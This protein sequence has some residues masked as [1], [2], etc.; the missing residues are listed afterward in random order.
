MSSIFKYALEEQT[1]QK[2]KSSERS[3]IFQKAMETK[4]P[5][6]EREEFDPEE[7]SFGQSALR[8]ASRTGAG[9]LQTAAG[10][11][12]DLL[13]V[14]DE[15]A[16]GPLSKAITGKEPTPYEK[17][18][19]GRLLPTGQTLKSG[20]S[21]YLKPQSKGEAAWDEFVADT[22]SLAIPFGKAKKAAQGASALGKLGKKVLKSAGIAGAGV[23]AESAAKGLGVNEDTARNVKIGTVLLG[24]LGNGAGF[25][26]AEKLRNSLYDEA[27]SLRDPLAKVDSINLKGRLDGLRKDLLKGSSSDASKKKTLQLITDTQDKIKKGKIPVS[28]LEELKISL[29]EARSG[30]FEDFKVDKKGRA[31]ARRNLNEFGSV[32]DKSLDEYGKQNP[33]WHKLYKE[34]NEVHG[35]IESSK[36]MSKFIARHTSKIAPSSGASLLAAAIYNPDKLLPIAGSLATGG[37][38]IKGSELVARIMKSPRLRKHYLDV[39]DGALRQDAAFMNHNLQKLS[40][41]IEKNPEDLLK[42]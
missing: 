25:K 8:N 22:T 4:R 24:S 16:V 15:Y 7:E 5:R 36:K 6:K 21:S 19:L 10:I 12:G 9:I 41:E 39:L 42:D 2:P 20:N 35:A 28:E 26:G 33:E 27:R 1:A 31:R 3:S 34:A 30:L 32:L 14:A 40:D 29:N 37:G 11:P 17:T 18:P 13:S 23:G 38:I